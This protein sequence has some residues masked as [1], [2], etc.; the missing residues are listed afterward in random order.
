[1]AKLA[2]G[3]YWDPEVKKWVS[4]HSMLKTFRRCPKQTEY[5]YVE[6]LKP[7]TLGKPLRQG[8]WMHKLLEEDAKT[9]DWRQAHAKQTK[10]FDNLFDE[11]KAD[12]G[13]LP[14]ECA[15]MMRAYKWHY[16]HDPWK[17]IEVEFIVEAELPD[18]TLYRGRVDF[19]VE[20]QYGL[21]IVDHKFNA[22]LPSHTFRLLDGQSALYIWA[23]RQMGI[24]VQGHIWNYMVRKPPTVPELAYANDPRRRRMSLKKI[25]TDYPT[26]K[27]ALKA[28]ELD[29][30]DYGAQLEYLRSLRFEHGMPQRSPF[31]RR[32][33]ME[34]DQKVIDQVVREAFHT[35][36]RMNSYPFGKKSVE[37]A[38]DY[39]CERMCKY[40]E[41]CSL[42]LFGGNTSNLR[43]QR[44]EITDPLYYYN[45]DPREEEAA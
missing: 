42:E 10:K 39:T 17:I 5:K 44:F 26:Y 1:M 37:R 28:Y 38:V 40:R 34:K 32:D 12:I 41:L 45:D 43:R 3:L 13:D 11:E 30:A 4:T 15:R 24:P 23:A 35:S 25:D 16:K 31:F 6:R 7:K 22:K 18:G 33:V 20:D 2:E 27:A 36:R 29:P 8:T 19:L 14:S 9:G 21:W